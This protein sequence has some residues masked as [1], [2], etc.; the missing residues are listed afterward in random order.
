MHVLQLLRLFSK[1]LAGRLQL[2]LD[3]GQGFFMRYG[4]LVDSLF[5]I[6]ACLFKLCLCSLLLYPSLLL[7]ALCSL[8]KDAGMFDLSPFK[9]ALENL[10]L[11]TITDSNGLKL[12]NLNT[13]F[14]DDAPSNHLLA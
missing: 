14:I 10:E 8:L 13:E 9:L 6:R 11:F 2:G 12:L 7:Q 1:V 3:S 5:V 4:K